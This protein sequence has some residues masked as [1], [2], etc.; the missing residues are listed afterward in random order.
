MAE[1]RPTAAELLDTPGALLTRSHLREL[2]L[3]RRAVD[4]V[5][6]RSPSSCS[7]ATSGR[8]SARPTTGRCSRGTRTRGTA[9]DR[10][11]LRDLRPGRPPQ[12]RLRPLRPAAH[13]ERRGLDPPPAGEPGRLAGRAPGGALGGSGWP[14]LDRP[15]LLWLRKPNLIT[16][17]STYFLALLEASDRLVK[18][19]RP[20]VAQRLHTPL[21]YRRCQTT[22]RLDGHLSLLANLELGRDSSPRSA[23]RLLQPSESLSWLRP[24][25]TWPST[26]TT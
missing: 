4:A 10:E 1:C 11:H 7:P 21:H 25:A 18:D 22:R 6:A 3:E 15:L 19:R 8:S 20:V 17:L 9:C 24:P 26:S 23:S 16:A 12:A 2:G 13:R 5:S 14:R